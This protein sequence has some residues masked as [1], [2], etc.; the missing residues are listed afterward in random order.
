MAKQ[1]TFNAV[2]ICNYSVIPIDKNPSSYYTVKVR[3][4]ILGGSYGRYQKNS[5]TSHPDSL[6]HR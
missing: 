6:Q 4:R 3:V 5:E 2:P 1:K